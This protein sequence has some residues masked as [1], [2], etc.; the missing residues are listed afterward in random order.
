M[1]RS[2]TDSGS[3]ERDGEIMKGNL[4]DGYAPKNVHACTFFGA[5]EFLHSACEYQLTT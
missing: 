3:G 2:S 1:A 5:F 4:P